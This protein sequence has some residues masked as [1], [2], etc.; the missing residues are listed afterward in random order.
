[1]LYV[2]RGAPC[3]WAG[4]LRDKSYSAEPSVPRSGLGP[5]FN[6]DNQTNA[7]NNRSRARTCSGI[8][9]FVA[10]ATQKAKLN[11][12]S[13]FPAFKGKSKSVKC[14][15]ADSVDGVHPWR[16]SFS[17]RR[18][19]LAARWSTRSSELNCAAPGDAAS[20]GEDFYLFGLSA[21]PQHFKFFHG[22]AQDTR[23]PGGF[24]LS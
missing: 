5:G 2:W 23:S 17:E 20:H 15:R 14:L 8:V 3:P 10:Q 6:N 11:I 24:I 13:G 7:V 12:V 22:A 4:P 19:L 18:R 16:R 1:M 21:R 9:K